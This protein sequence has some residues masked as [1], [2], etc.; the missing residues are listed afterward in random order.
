MNT[1]CSC[2]CN[3]S[4]KSKREAIV[5][6]QQS[7]VA[8]EETETSQ[9]NETE[10]PILWQILSIRTKTEK[11]LNNHKDGNVTGK[12]SHDKTIQ[13]IQIK[14]VNKVAKADS[15]D[16]IDENEETNIA[17]EEGKITNQQRLNGTTIESIVLIKNET[18]NIL[19]TTNLPITST[20]AKN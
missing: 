6:E 8:A 10:D 7:T 3:N 1:N 17:E 9:E 16:A 5:E 18:T 11:S 12:I 15:T 20:K 14:Y 4:S 13:N 2:G 19:S